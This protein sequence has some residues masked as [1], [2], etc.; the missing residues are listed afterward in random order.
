MTFTK[1][2]GQWYKIRF[3][4]DWAYVHGDFIKLVSSSGGGASSRDLSGRVIFIDPG[5]GGK[6]PGAVVNGVFES[7]LVMQIANKLKADLE[8]SGA[9]VIMSRSNDTFVALGDRVKLA[10]GS[11]AHIFVSLHMNSFML[12][13]ASGVEMF[14]DRTNSGAGSKKLA[15]SLQ[16]EMVNRVGMRNRGVIERNLEVIRFTR[17]PAVLAELGFMTN[18]ND[19]EVLRN[20]QDQI[21]D[22]LAEGIYQY[23]K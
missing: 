6:D 14:Y 19:M 16:R 15:E 23:F 2:S 7:H 18:P 17:M 3:N 5:H 1:K 11:N 20:G 4:N 13:T 10:N 8:S 9:T 22:A 12:P 21:V